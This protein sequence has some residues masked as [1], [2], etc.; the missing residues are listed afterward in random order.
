MCDDGGTT[1][2]AIASTPRLAEGTAVDPIALEP[3][4]EIT[5]TTLV[6]NSYDALMGDVGPARRRGMG[7]VPAA[8]APQFEGGLASPGLIAEHGFS[9]LVSTRRDN[10]T[11]TVLFDTGIS[12]DGMAINFE[13]MGLDAS[14]IEAVVLSHGHVDHDGGFP[15]LARLRGRSGLPLAVH[16][17]VFSRRRFALPNAPAMELP[18]L[19]RSALEAEGFEVIERRQPSLLLDGSVLLTG[20]VDRTTEFERGLPN[21]EAWRDGRWEPDPLLLDEQAL[22]VHVRGKGLVVLTGCGHAG[23]VNIARHAMRLTGVDRLHAL[24]GGFHLTGQVFEP[25]I[26]PTVDAFLELRPDTLVPAHCTGWKAQHRFA[27]ALP[28]AFVPNAVGTA[29]TFVAA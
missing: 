15:G 22:V 24:L 9:A 27:A 23:A 5:I 25:I 17:L 20:E 14:A 26:E 2:E 6:D 11:H 13:R 8:A 10:R 28:D 4:D 16:P 21:H 12:P 3:V 19:S 18:T 29:F 1:A 7:T